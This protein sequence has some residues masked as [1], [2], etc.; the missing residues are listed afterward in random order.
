MPTYNVA[1]AAILRKQ[2]L[3]AKKTNYAVR[4]NGGNPKNSADV[5]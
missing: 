1:L 2:V 5:R 4:L 3:G